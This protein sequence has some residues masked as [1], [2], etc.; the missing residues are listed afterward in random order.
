MT[1]CIFCKIVSGE[2]PSD[3][4]YEDDDVVA[5]DD[6]NPQSPAHTLIIPKRHI[7]TLNDLTPADA[8]LIGKLFL[9]AKEVAKIKGVDEAGYR[10]LINCNKDGGQVVFHIHL[11][12][13]GGRRMGWPPG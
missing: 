11:H 3:F 13:M 4:V 5:F 6:M 12:M 2:I 1:D 8:E 7:S 10:T 9:G